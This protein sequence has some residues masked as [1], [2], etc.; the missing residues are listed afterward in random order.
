[1]TKKHF[2]ELADVVRYRISGNVSAGEL[3]LV[4]RAL[5]DFCAS[6]N[7]SFNRQL[8]MDYIAGECGPSGGRVKRDP[9]SGS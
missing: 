1:M 3:D 2:I 5:A 9:R 7:P 6:Q 4:T 8:W